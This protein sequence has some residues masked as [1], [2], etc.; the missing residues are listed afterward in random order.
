MKYAFAF[1]LSLLMVSGPLVAETPKKPSANSQLEFKRHLADK[2]PCTTA[3][4]KWMRHYAP[5]TRQL[6]T[7]NGR[8]RLLFNNVLTKMHAAGL[9]SEYALIPFVES[10]Y[11]PTARSP[12]GP[13]GLWQFTAR[14]ARNHGLKVSGKHDERMNP[15]RSTDA[16]IKYLRYLHRKFKGHTESVLMAFNAG[17]GRVMASRRKNGRKLSGITHVYPDKITAISCN[18]L[19]QAR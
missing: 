8:G 6:R 10:H 14:T 17:E 18:I 11:V 12:L 19:Q 4:K 5:Y 15:A 2:A 3:R 13:A 9:P 16:A 1:G 7:T